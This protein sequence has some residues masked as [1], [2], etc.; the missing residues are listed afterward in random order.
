MQSDASA[1]PDATPAA[2][3]ENNEINQHAAETQSDA[4]RRQ[5]TP[6]DADCCPN[7]RNSKEQTSGA[8]EASQASHRSPPV[9]NMFAPD[10]RPPWEDATSMAADDGDDLAADGST[11]L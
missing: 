11:E 7:L 10:L 6:A 8:S 4:T 5:P 1:A 3:K 2:A 9:E